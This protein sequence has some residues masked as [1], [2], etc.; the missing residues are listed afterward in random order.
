VEIDEINIRFAVDEG[1]LQVEGKH[2]YSSFFPLPDS[3]IPPRV[4]NAELIQNM[5][6]FTNASNMPKAEAETRRL[7]T[8]QFVSNCRFMRLFC[9]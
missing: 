7:Q 3:L 1:F 5:H 8:L 6:A 4:A 9:S 2:K